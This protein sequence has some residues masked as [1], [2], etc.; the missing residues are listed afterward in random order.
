MMHKIL[1]RTLSRQKML[2]FVNVFFL[3]IKNL[4][5]VHGKL[6]MK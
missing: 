1:Q 4:C 3:S 6:F 2:D 5:M